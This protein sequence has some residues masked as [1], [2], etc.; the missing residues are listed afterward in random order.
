MPVT[1]AK[2]KPDGQKRHRVKPTYDWTEVPDVPF[3]GAPVLPKT[4]GKPKGQA[5]PMPPRPLG[6][7]G[8]GLWER[9][10]QTL[11]V[12][13]VD[14]NALLTVCEQ[15]D[16]RVALRGRVLRDGDWRDR[17]AL[18]VLDAQVASRLAQFAP[19]KVPVSWPAETRRW[20]KAIS[21]MPHCVL[22]DESDWQ[23][24]LDTA[25]LVAAFH[26][27]DL[28]LAGEIRAREKVLG[29]TG[30]AR[31]DLRIRYVDPNAGEVDEVDKGS[32]TAMADY[33]RMAAGT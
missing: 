8:L 3:D 4:V 15:M 28:R 32:V 27:G 24:A 17:S 10:W 13:S 20:W 11:A 9:C 31:R 30:D 26:T 6:T 7:A 22:W 29:T 12:G 16:E 1:G 19:D 21:R 14:A 33:R 25:V 2:P 18:R 23:F 5:P